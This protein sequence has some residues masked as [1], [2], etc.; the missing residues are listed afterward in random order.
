MIHASYATIATDDAEIR[1]DIEN[2]SLGGVYC[3]CPAKYKA[4]FSEQQPLENMEL[5]LTLEHECTVVSIRQA[6]VNRIEA[7]PRPKHFGVA[8]EFMRVSRDAKKQLVKLIY[9]L[10]RYIL[11]NRLKFIE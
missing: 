2:I 8:F 6:Q 11:Q 1:L 3:Y 10:Q 4:R 5:V 9:E 7:A